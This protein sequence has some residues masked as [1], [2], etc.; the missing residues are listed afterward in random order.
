MNK[1]MRISL[2]SLLLSSSFLYSG[3]SNHAPTP[4]E[5]VLNSFEQTSSELAGDHSSLAHKFKKWI[6]ND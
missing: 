3:C 1:L 2:S 6:R 4:E 5:K